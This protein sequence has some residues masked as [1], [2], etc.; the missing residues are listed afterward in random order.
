V[1]VV[2]ATEIVHLNLEERRVKDGQ[3]RLEGS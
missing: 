2:A 3:A 1:A